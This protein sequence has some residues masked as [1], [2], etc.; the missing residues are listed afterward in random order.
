MLQIAEKHAD[1]AARV[2]DPWL[3]AHSMLLLALLA[4]D[5]HDHD[6]QAI[7]AFYDTIESTLTPRLRAAIL[8]DKQRLYGA[9][10]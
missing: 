8:R 2:K 7:H 1:V 5:K 4:R 10:K 9:L 6:V 3:T